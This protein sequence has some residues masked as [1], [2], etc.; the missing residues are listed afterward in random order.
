L[1]RS[2]AKNPRDGTPPRIRLASTPK[3][4]RSG[5]KSGR[6]FLKA[7]AEEIWIRD[8]KSRGFYLQNAPADAAGNSDPCPDFPAGAG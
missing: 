6:C 1:S 5:T 8:Q 4:I 7:G 3:H 2:S